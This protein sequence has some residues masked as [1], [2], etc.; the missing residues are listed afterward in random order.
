MASTSCH[1]QWELV[2]D[3]HQHPRKLPVPPLDSVAA[4]RSRVS[5]TAPCHALQDDPSAGL[6]SASLSR[7]QVKGQ[8]LSAPFP[9]LTYAEAME[10]YGCDKPDTRYGLEL[11]TVSAA[12]TGSAFRCG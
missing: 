4:Q 10:R 3:S 5:D 9:R 8:Q 11:R 12:V 1:E 6:Q 7:V 2:C